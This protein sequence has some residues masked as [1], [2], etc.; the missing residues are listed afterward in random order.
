MDQTVHAGNDLSKRAEG[1]QLDDADVGH[2]ADLVGV[3]EHIPGILGAVLH[4]ERDLVLLG[5][6]GENVH[7][8]M[9][10]DRDDL[11]GILDAAPA[12]LGDVD[13]TVHA[14]DIDEHAVA[15]HGLDHA[16]IVLADLDV[17]PDLSL[18]GRTGLVLHSLDGAD[19]AAAGTVDLGDAE[20]N[21]LLDELAQVAVLGQTALGSGNEHTHALDGNDDAA[22]V[23]FGDDALEN[24]LVLN[25]ILD[26]LP[27]LDRVEALL[28]KGGIALH[29]VDA[30]DVGLDLVA[31]MD[32]VLDLGVGIAGKLADG[33]VARLLAAQV[34]LDLGRTDGRDDT[35]H[36]IS[37]I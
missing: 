23:F 29:V 21:A 36:L 1:H 27:D 37:C 12:Q 14:A 16:V 35:G 26:V 24:S 33:N 34:D 5:I 3:H 30:D 20:L 9:I 19:D 28:G 15:G 6:E 10:A 2:V 11:G 25:G 18:R 7:V 22:L 8:E 32:D 13:H 4:A 17:G 31:D